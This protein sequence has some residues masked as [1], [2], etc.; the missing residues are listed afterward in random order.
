[1]IRRISFLL[2]LV[3]LS[4]ATARVEAQGLSTPTVGTNES[5][6]ATADSSAVYF[7]PAMTAFGTG[8]A[9]LFLG[10]T[11]VIGDIRYRRDYRATYQRPDSLDFALPIEPSAIDQDKAGSAEQVQSNPVAPAPML[12]ATVPIDGQRLDDR[13]VLGFG[14]YSPY[15]AILSFPEDGAQR[16]Q[17]TD[18]IIATVFVTPT[19]SF[20]V[21]EA[22]SIGAGVSYVGGFAEIRRVQDFAALADVGG[23][24]ARPPISQ[25]NDFGPDAPPGV[26]ELDVMARPFVLRRAFAHEGTFNVGIAV[27]PATGLRLGLSYQHSTRMRFRGEFELDM[28]DDFFTQDLA[29]QGLEFKPRVVGD[30]TLRFTLP[31]IIR[32]GASLQN[33]FGGVALDVAYTFWSQV[34]SFQVTATSPDLAQPEVG[35]GSTT[36]IRLPRDWRNTIGVDGVGHLNPSRSFRMWGRIGF[37]QAAVPDSTIDVASPDGNRIVIGGGGAIR[38][39]RKVSLIG[40]FGAQIVP[41]RRVVASDYDLGNGTYRLM[42]FTVN[43]SLRITL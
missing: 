6:A 1:M 35:L 13:L 33:E 24:L 30:A 26:R 4:T 25:T 18:A 39:S 16:F 3:V 38:A 9:E 32:F 11:L 7:N 41:E 19:L 14:A 27:Q 43:G 29:S 36:T 8:D 2:G 5:T 15:A 40:D 20:R 31:R 12:F 22:F 17:L 10:A 42:L 21:S 28:D 37:R 23:A 34:D